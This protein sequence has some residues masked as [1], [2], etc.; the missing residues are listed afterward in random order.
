MPRGALSLKESAPVV[1]LFTCVF[2][3]VS[4]RVVLVAALK[5]HCYA[6]HWHMTMTH[7]N[8]P[9]GSRGTPW[10]GHPARRVFLWWVLTNVPPAS[11][12]GVTCSL[13]TLIVALAL[14]GWETPEN[15]A[16]AAPRST[17]NFLLCFPLRA[18]RTGWHFVWQRTRH[19]LIFP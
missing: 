6:R 8:Q 3:W 17:E 1:N 2:S 7:F 19:A 11:R 13:L 18:P 12:S 10:A 9:G 15:S 4:L 5:M 16:P 14:S